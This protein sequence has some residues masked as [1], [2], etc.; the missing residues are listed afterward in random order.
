MKQELTMNAEPCPFK[1]S[2]I[3]SSK[4]TCDG[5]LMFIENYGVKV[6]IPKGAIENSCVEVQAAASL[7]GPF[8]VPD[9]CRPV[10]P[11]VWIASNYVFK[12]QLQIEIEHHADISNVKE[13]SKKLCLL[14]ACYS[15]CNAHPKMYMTTGSYH[16][17]INDTTFTL[18]TNHFC[19]VCLAAENKQIP[20]RIVAYQYLPADYVSADTFR[21]EVCFCY[22]LT[23][24]KEVNSYNT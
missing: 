3:V 7:F 1:D 8:V 17:I 11:Y 19:S 20:D 13:I 21:A 4:F 10:S 22:D 24:C 6:I 14:K 12:K 2:D 16:Y 23:I 15:K 5:G 9:N 18:F